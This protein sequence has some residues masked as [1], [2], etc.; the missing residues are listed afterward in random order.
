MHV[1]LYLVL[2]D[3][4]TGSLCSSVRSCLLLISQGFSVCSVHGILG[5]FDI[6]RINW[7]NLC[8]LIFSIRKRLEVFY[9]PRT[10]FLNRLGGGL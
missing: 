5:K 10:Q 1:I 2:R 3:D 6:E 4:G 9:V 7:V 8:R